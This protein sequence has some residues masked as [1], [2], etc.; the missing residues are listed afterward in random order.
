MQKLFKELE[1]R[2]EANA[3]GKIPYSQV[4]P[5]LQEVQR[6]IKA[7]ET[8]GDRIT[9][10][11]VCNY[12]W[13]AKAVNKFYHDLDAKFRACVGQF[14]LLTAYYTRQSVMFPR[15]IR[16]DIFLGI[17]QEGG[18]ILKLENGLWEL[19]TE[20]YVSHLFD[21]KAEL[22]QGNIPPPDKLGNGNLFLDLREG[23]RD[24]EYQPKKLD[25]A[26]G[27]KNIAS[28]GLKEYAALLGRKTK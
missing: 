24:S 27:D 21:Q 17:I 25:L 14:V 5:V 8:L 11:T 13:P 2:I 7:G 28:F 6:R 23:Y 26:I 20:K 3:L 19:P 12:G 15:F 10:F 22:K 1:L 18:L 4:Q 9:D 16:S